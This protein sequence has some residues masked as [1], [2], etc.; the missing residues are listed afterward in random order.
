MIEFLLGVGFDLP[1]AV[2]Y[3]P[4]LLPTHNSSLPIHLNLCNSALFQKLGK[5]IISKTIVGA[6]ELS[7][8]GAGVGVVG[9]VAFF[10]DNNFFAPFSA[11]CAQR[12]WSRFF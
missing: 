12:F 9:G 6:L 3:L 5:R 7:L 8:A 10:Y 4:T 2:T 11:Y 1:V